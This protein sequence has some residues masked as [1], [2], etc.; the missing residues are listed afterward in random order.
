[1]GERYAAVQA[2]RTN[3]C[4]YSYASVLAAGSDVDE[5]NRRA[6]ISTITL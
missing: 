2:V 6:D 1:M 3:K 4:G 5:S